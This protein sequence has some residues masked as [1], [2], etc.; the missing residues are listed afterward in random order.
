MEDDGSV[1]N[2]KCMTLKRTKP[3]YQVKV[4][5]LQLLHSIL[6]VQL[7]DIKCKVGF[8]NLHI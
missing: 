3:L 8:A 2:P 7:S 6:I 4:I 5:R 1:V